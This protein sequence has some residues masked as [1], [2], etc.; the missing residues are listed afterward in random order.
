[1]VQS[2]NSFCGFHFFEDQ[3]IEDGEDVLAVGEDS[4]DGG[5]NPG[6]TMGFAVPAL[7]DLRRDIDIFPQLLQRMAAQEEAVEKYR[8]VLGFTELAF[9]RTAHI[10]IDVKSAVV[11]VKRNRPLQG[12]KKDIS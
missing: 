11:D 6:G 9:E 5:P 1:M 12:D 8:F 7:D 2:L 10:R 3:R 4:L